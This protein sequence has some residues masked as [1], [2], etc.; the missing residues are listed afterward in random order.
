[1]AKRAAGGSDGESRAPARP[2]ARPSA[3]PRPRKGAADQSPS[4]KLALTVLRL[5]TSTQGVPLSEL[6]EQLDVKTRGF[7]NYK[8]RL[9]QVFADFIGASVKLEEVRDSCGERWIRLVAPLQV[10]QGWALVAR[11]AAYDFLGS[12]LRFMGGA[13]LK[14]QV[15]KAE[16]EFL[17]RVDRT[18][19]GQAKK[20][21]A[22]MFFV[23]P[24]APKDYSKSES[25]DV[26]NALTRSLW[27]GQRVEVLYTPPGKDMA[28]YRLEPLTLSVHRSALY[29]FA[30][31]VGK[32]A[33]V[34]NLAVDR[35]SRVRPLKEHYAYPTEKEWSPAEFT[36]RSFG[37]FSPPASK[38]EA[39]TVEL[40]FANLPWLKAHVRE[41]RWARDQKFVEMPDGRFRMTFTVNS[42]I[43]VGPWVRQWGEHVTV[44]RPADLAGA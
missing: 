34:Y 22:R 37:I 26:I 23:V 7:Y 41:R 15:V 19:R 2:R 28:I 35:I 31:F 44:V 27:F 36:D 11:M 40:V 24:D 20:N 29:L 4:L 25:V 10:E 16:D 30:R 17:S 6:K 3:S 39:I 18:L 9:E 5:F 32:P 33:K 13:E 14:N 42:L 12:L 8:R 43:E 38:R 1:M 21:L